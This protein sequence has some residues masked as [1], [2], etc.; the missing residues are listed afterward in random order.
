M[1]TVF[2]QQLELDIIIGVYEWEKQRTQPVIIDVEMA[3][4]T[5]SAAKSDD[6]SKALDYK[7]VVDAIEALA[8]AEPFELVETL[9]DRIALTLER[10][11]KVSACR[12]SVAKPDA[13]EKANAVGVRIRRGSAF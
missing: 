7:A 5:Q 8:K 1:D 13:I 4:D 6:L 10:D 9:A 11:F 12:I 3:W 2:I